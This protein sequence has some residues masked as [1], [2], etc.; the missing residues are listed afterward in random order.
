MRELQPGLWYWQAP[1]P[2]WTPSERWPQV[3]S[4]YAIDDG[5]RLILFDPQSVPDQLLELAGDREPAVVLSAPWHERDTRALV[6]RFGVPVYVPRPD[7]AEDLIR[8]FG[9]TADEAGSG[10]PDVA[11]LLAGEGHDAHFYG[12]GS[13]LPFG[14]DALLGREENDLV[15]WIESFRAVI[16]GDTLVDFGNG[17]EI[18]R[19]LRGGVTRQDVVERL[20]PLLSRPVSWV[21]P[22]HGTPTDKAALERALVSR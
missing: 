5:N 15:L 1:H 3:V 6:D 14:I 9:I 22:T 7:S 12:A 13:R 20:Q 10:S 16:P 4:S 2:E 17:F 19:W 21:L 11:W 18:N 8:K